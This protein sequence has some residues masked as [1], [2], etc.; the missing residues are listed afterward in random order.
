MTR[1]VRA[2]VFAIA[3]LAPLAAQAVSFTFDTLP[4]SGILSAAP[5]ETLGFG[6]TIQNSSSTDWLVITSLD[7][8]VFLAGAADAALFDFPVLAPGAS[9]VTPF[10]PGASGLF[11]FTWDSNAPIGTANSGDFVL[12]GEW[13]SGDPTAGGVF[14]TLATPASATYQV[15]LTPEP[16]MALLLVLVAPLLVRL[17]SGKPGRSKIHFARGWLVRRWAGWKTDHALGG[18][19]GERIGR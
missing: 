1:T 14:L 16:G 17:R 11:A 9:L 18:E 4:A 2:L 12:G 15:L 13:W 5:G 10:V 8:G 19:C 6:Y 3:V 7:A